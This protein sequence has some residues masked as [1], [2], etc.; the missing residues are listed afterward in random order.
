MCLPDQ[1]SSNLF[2]TS[3]NQSPSAPESSAGGKARVSGMSVRGDWEL[4]GIFR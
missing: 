2:L 3:S 4:S 1:N